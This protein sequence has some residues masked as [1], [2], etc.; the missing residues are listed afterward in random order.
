[1]ANVKA[2]FNRFVKAFKEGRISKKDLLK[3]KEWATGRDVQARTT[4]KEF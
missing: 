1:M 3:V 4:F 2:R